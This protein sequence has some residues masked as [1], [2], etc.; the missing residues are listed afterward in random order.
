[1]I[2]AEVTGLIQA[3][4]IGRAL[5]PTEVELIRTVFPHPTLLEEPQVAVLD[6]WGRAIRHAHG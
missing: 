2:G 5:K 1:M 6:A 4:I 3:F